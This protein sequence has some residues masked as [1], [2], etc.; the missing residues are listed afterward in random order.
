MTNII[1]ISTAIN[2]YIRCLE[3]V[4]IYY[5]QVACFGTDVHTAFLKALLSTGFKLPKKAILIGIQVRPANEM[6]CS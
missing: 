6:G 1:L 5:L 3:S 4:S 2:I